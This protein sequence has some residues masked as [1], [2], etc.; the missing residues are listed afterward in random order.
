MDFAKRKRFLDVPSNKREWKAIAKEFASKWNFPHA[1]GAIDGKH[2]VMQAT[3][4]SGS[5]Y[6]NY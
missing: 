4:N 1:L 6:F 5:E 3:S 2:V